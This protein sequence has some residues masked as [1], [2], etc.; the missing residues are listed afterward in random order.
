MLHCN[1]F[2]GNA[3]WNFAPDRD[4]NVVSFAVARLRFRRVGAVMKVT[5]RLPEIGIGSAP[6]RAKI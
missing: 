3:R 4:I 5:A 1:V 6:N 2:W